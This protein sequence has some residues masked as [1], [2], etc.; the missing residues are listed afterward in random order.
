M[1]DSNQHSISVLKF[2]ELV[3]FTRQNESFD[4]VKFIC[5]VFTGTDHNMPCP[6]LLQFQRWRHCNSIFVN[7][8]ILRFYS[9]FTC[10]I[11]W[12]LSYTFSLKQN[13]QINF[14]IGFLMKSRIPKRLDIFLSLMGSALFEA[15][16]VLIIEAW[17]H[18]FR[19]RT[20]DLAILKGSVSIITGVLFLFDCIFT[21]KNK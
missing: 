17:E 13:Y 12:W 7:W 2:L 3:C 1:S 5:F 19:T 10:S 9:N 11:F 14:P 20:R 4:E 8:H 21:F 16:G 6:S 18:S 15:T